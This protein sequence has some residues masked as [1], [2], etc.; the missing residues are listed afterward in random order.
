MKV[1]PE[2]QDAWIQLQSI[3]STRFQSSWAV[4]PHTENAITCILKLAFFFAFVIV[5]IASRKNTGS[6]RRSR[7]SILVG[8]LASLV[9]LAQLAVLLWLLATEWPV[10]SIV[11]VFWLAQ[12]ISWGGVGYSA[13]ASGVRRAAKFTA[14]I[15]WIA[16]FVMNT[17]ITAWTIVVLVRE[18]SSAL[19]VY[20]ILSI[21]AWPVCCV[22]LAAAAVKLR[23]IWSGQEQR[24][25]ERDLVT[26]LLNGDG[27]V[28]IPE[29]NVTPLA[30]AGFWSQLSFSWMNPL[31][32]LGHSRPLELQDIPVLPPEY[33]AQT[34]HLDFA[35]RLELQRKHGARISVF[36]AL[37]GCFGKEFLY[38]GFLALVRTLALSSSPL[39]TYFFVRSV[40]KPQG[41]KLGF[42]RVEGFAII[43]GLT[44]AK[45]LQSISQR[46]WSFQSR[47]VGARL[48]S[49]VIAEVYE[50]QLRLANSATQRHGAGEIVSY[51]GVD[52]YRLGDF[53]WWMHYTWT[54]V[55]QLGIAIGILV[56]TIGLATLACVAVLVVTACIQIPTSRL[57]Q[58]AQ[59]NFMVAQDK[60]LRATT[61]ILT[62][63][64]I[65]KL[66]AWEEEFKTL[67]KQHREEELQW[68][69]SMHGKRSVSL[70]TFWFSYTVAVAVALAGYAFLG[71]KLTAAVIFTVFSAFGNTQEP[72]RI[73]PELLAI[74]T[75]VKVSLLRLGRFLQD[76]EVDTNAVDRR[77]LKGNDV[78]VRARGGF[79]SWDGSH[80]SL[81][82]ANFEIHR[83][84]KVAICGAVGSGKSS[85]LSA[86]L[87]EI[88]KISGT[89]Q[90]Y[91]TVA[92]VSQSAWIQTGT[93]RDNVVF[94]KPYDEQKYQNVLKACALESDLKIL[95]HGDKT[96]IGERGLNLSGGQKQ[97][98]QLA[99]AVYYDSDIYFLDDPFSA[100]DAHTAATLFHDCVMKALAGKTVLLVTH[101]V[102]FLP[103]VDKILVMQDGEVL[104]SGN[105]DE[106][107]ESG[108]AFEK[109][110]NAHKEALDN[111]NN[112]Q[113]E[114]QMSE[115]KSNKDPE[116]K[117]HIS[118][119]RRNSSKKQQ[120]HSESFTA[121]QLTE[122]EEMGVGD[123][124]LQPYKDYLTISKARFF[125]IVDLVAQAGL[126]AGQAAASLY[127]AIQV[128]NPDI[129]AKLLVGG[130]T[131]ISW[132]TSFCFIIR[133][134]AHIAMGLKASREFFYRLM[135][136][137]FKAPMSFFDST[138]TGRILS[139]ASNDM[140]LLDIDLNQISNI[141]IGFLF[142]LPSVFIILIYVVWPYFVFVIP[143]LYMIKRVEKYFRSTAQS[144]MRLNAMT[145][146][147]IVNMSGET[148]NGVT[149]IRA[150]GVADEFRRKNL[151]LLDK[152]VSLYMHN[153][154]VMEWLVLRVESCGTVLLC[155]FGIMLSTFDIGPGLA[156]MGLSYGALVN[157]SLVVLTQWY[158]QLANTIVSVERIKQYM[159]VPVEA[160]PIIEN[161]RP[162]P[163]WP[164]KGE[165]VL[166]KL[167]IRYRPNSPLVL[168]GIS[169]TIQGGHKVGVVGR[170]GS[171]KTTLIGALFR[172]VE[173]V[174]GTILID[175]IDIC[176]IGLRDLRTKLGIIPQE[177]TLFRGTVRSNLDPLGS[178]SDQEI[179][180]TLDKCQMGDVIRSLP[181]QLE[182]GVA[183]EGGNWSAGQRQLFCLGRVLLRRSRILVLDEATA[184]IDSTTDAVLQKV[185]REEFASCT[186]VTV[187]HRIPTVI[188]SDRVMALHDGRLAEYESPQ[189]L[190][191]NPDS[192]F[193]KLVKEYWAQSGGGK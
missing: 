47:L 163:E 31:L 2:V 173:P 44:A 7:W 52:A 19:T 115:S 67:I 72:V 183:D 175:G 50:K 166:E 15:W 192:L 109:L 143:M 81:K 24:D 54:L 36:K 90:L 122:K 131:L 157:I 16:M 26:P 105:Y 187:A 51:I 104:Q 84:D 168:R 39:F 78:V 65:I 18:S 12:T 88:P 57:L 136:S 111:F 145:K 154:S 86:L 153:Y 179:W 110:V 70:I 34:N 40:A 128:Q 190:L 102:E 38:T 149:S 27:G 29:K 20:G 22:L 35:Q 3:C 132:S 62:S 25:E 56:G 103:A 133:M 121:S 87:G 164:S 188:D 142:D 4:L 8:V 158:C 138:P 107:V 58:R 49:A 189:K 64:K 30:T 117:R 59:T 171:G 92:Y 96:E 148:I 170:T 5:H 28:E 85:L 6:R 43:L 123:L 69:G 176:S 48:R 37:A 139:R 77:S 140:S 41:E 75:Q 172:L 17:V 63:M 11:W 185:I 108:L 186:V 13:M 178:Y 155:I 53:A 125:F 80:P 129:N 135:D 151:V 95:P 99:R 60:R 119:V 83:G 118:I 82:N 71:N 141:I 156:G 98:I 146:A 91:G 193:A 120:D 68:L 106:L 100:V 23:E 137:L 101:Q 127:L 191:Q 66:Q 180:E 21:A 9:A 160:P 152:D 182:S 74:I 184:S 177:P 61:E 14:C 1:R 89:V 76:E 174:G 181:E 162:P 144:L 161:N 42:F 126:V 10:D 124:G 167:Q 150:F 94:G 112:Q 46:H 33:S 134:R 147:P 159:N 116:F 32:D 45:F 169:C 79:F 55:L 165:I 97:R 114:Q 73:V 130:Y 113:Q 93:I